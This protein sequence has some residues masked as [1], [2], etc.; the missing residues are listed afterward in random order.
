MGS[1]TTDTLSNK[2][3][4]TELH[5]EP[6]AP[7]CEYQAGKDKALILVGKVALRQGELVEKEIYIENGVITSIENSGTLT[8]AKPNAA[9]LVC[10]NAF[11]SPGLV[12]AHEHTGYSYK[13]PV[14][15]MSHDYQHRL[16]WR[17]GGERALKDQ[18][19]S[20]SD[21]SILAWVELRHLLS[22]ATTV[23]GSGGVNG[24]VRNVSSRNEIGNE[25]VDL[26]TDPFSKKSIDHLKDVCSNLVPMAATL[27]LDHRQAQ[28]VPH[29]GEG[30]NC[31]AEKEL[32]AY[33]NYASNTPRRQFSLIHGVM[34]QD[35]H[36]QLL[37]ENDISVIWSP[38]SNVAL[39]GQSLNPIPLMDKGVRVALGTDW[40]PSGSFNMFEEM[41]CAKIYSTA[42]SSRSVTDKELWMMS[43]IN[44]AH[45]LGLE[46][47]VGVI[48]V[49]NYA[50]IIVVNNPDNNGLDGFSQKNSSDVLAV[51]VGGTLMA[52]E[53]GTFLNGTM[54]Q[55]CSV[56]Y[57]NKFI[58]IDFKNDYQ[59]TF[60]QIIAKNANSVDL[61][62][63]EHQAECEFQ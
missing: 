11:F 41:R 63:L 30:V 36:H 15:D 57:G 5:A 19:T 34:L 33:L 3:V 59:Q 60:E 44:A 28:V 53:Q 52:G 13:F 10:K 56:T 45:A 47:K 2:E 18:P 51:F 1:C 39:Y 61:L 29:V 9:R 23:A 27:E 49:G 26:K 58:C 31:L 43:T 16:E 21:R 14:A 12:N 24:I 7:A 62:A 40:S 54:G 42:K 37:T 32:D 8:S 4:H 25:L 38:R 20:S 17:A 35:K 48:D 6:G 50:D 22:G 46:D 55:E